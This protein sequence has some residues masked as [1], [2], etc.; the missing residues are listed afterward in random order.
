MVVTHGKN[1]NYIYHGDLSG[2]LEIRHKTAEDDSNS[3]EVPWFEL[4]QI[5]AGRMRDVKISNAEQAEDEELLGFKVHKY[6]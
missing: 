4:L 6:E 2:P 3:I 5:V 1:F